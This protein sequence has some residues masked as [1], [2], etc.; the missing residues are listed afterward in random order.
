VI[1]YGERF[2]RLKKSAIP[3]IYV[4]KRKPAL[5]RALIDRKL[6]ILL[7]VSNVYYKAYQW[8]QKLPL[9]NFEIMKNSKDKP[10]L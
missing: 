5:N 3:V 8:R 6:K 4:L 9:Q 2:S 7:V 1:Q 10:A